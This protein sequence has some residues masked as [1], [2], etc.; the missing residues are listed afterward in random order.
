MKRHKLYLLFAIIVGIM[1]APFFAGC[2]E[3]IKITLKQPVNFGYE[4]N[5]ETGEQ[6]LVVEENPFASSYVFGVCSTKYENDLSKFLRYEFP[7]KYSTTYKGQQVEIPHNFFDV[8][9]IFK[10]AQTYYY[11]V[12]YKGQGKYL[13]SPISEVKSVNITYKLEAPYLSLTDTTL[14]WTSISNASTYSVYSII[15]G[16]RESVATTQETSYDIA[17]YLSDKIAENLGSQIEFFVYCNNTRNYLRSADSNT[18]VYNKHLQLAVPTNVRITNIAGED[19]ICWNP[20]KNCSS[21]TLKVNNIRTEILQVS[22]LEKN[23]SAFKYGLQK[24]YDEYGLGDYT[25]CIKS[26]NSANF[27]ES[28]YSVAATTTITKKL[29]TPQNVR[30]IVDATTVDIMWDIVDNAQE[31]EVEYTDIFD[32]NKIKKLVLNAGSGIESSIIKNHITVTYQQLNIVNG[33]QLQSDSY[34]IR[35][36]AVGYNY[37]LSSDCSTGKTAVLKYQTLDT[38]V[39]Q[40]DAENGLFHWDSIDGAV[41]YRFFIVYNGECEIANVTVTNFDYGIFLT[42]IG[43]YEFYCMAIAENELFNS[44]YSNTIEKE[45]NAVLSKP[46]INDIRIDGDKFVVSFD[47]D[48]NAV[49][50]T[51]YANNVEITDS[52]TI[53]SNKVGIVSAMPYVSNN[54]LLFTIKANPVGYYTGSEMSDAFIFGTEI[55]TPNISISGNMLTWD[56]ISNATSYSIYLDNDMREFSSINTSLDLTNYVAPNTSRQIRLV[57]N[58]LYLGNSDLSNVVMFSNVATQRPG[59]TDKFFNYGQTY[60][61]YITSTQELYDVIGY[62]YFNRISTTDIYLDYDS[63]VSISE[64]VRTAI[65][66]IATGTRNYSA[67]SISNGSRT[68]GPSRIVINQASISSAPTYTANTVQSNSYMSLKGNGSR[69]ASYKFPLEYSIVTQNVYTTDGL[70]AAVQHQVRPR[71]MTENSVE[72]RVYNKAKEVLIEIC[73]D[74]MT[75][76]QKALAIHDWI[77]LNVAYDHQGLNNVS[78]QDRLGYFHYIESALLYKLGVCDSYAKTY[79]LMCSLENIECVVVDGATDKNNQDNTGHSWNKIYLD[80]DADGD[81]EWAIV[82]CTWDDSS[83]GTTEYLKHQYFMIPDSY[84]EERYQA[85]EYPT[86]GIDTDAFYSIYRPYS[87]KLKLDTSSDVSALNSYLYSADRTVEVLVKSSLVSSI[88]GYTISFVYS[89]DENYRVVLVS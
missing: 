69:T 56:S 87:F 76:Y 16:E 14:S 9:N 40:D 28:E 58:N 72:E 47:G 17:E 41:K 22:Q 65:D 88:H 52:L 18:I 37:Y 75:D 6:T 57:A 70:L 63:S 23:G 82:D 83:D 60:D 4:I 54:R 33:L 25:F 86:T 48:I 53:V 66:Y 42:K 79:A 26:N 5:Q 3:E 27:V 81:K 55:R 62:S 45:V 85:K 39:L 49:T 74:S 51:L 24:Y 64:K 19:Y 36:K 84:F 13:N 34:I 78:I 61:Y 12:Q 68:T 32:N 21:Y 59:Y 46:S 20:V 10:N 15:D 1:F 31:Y 50:F 44:A 43:T 38:P 7:A 30:C 2:G 29:D 11:Y 71:F 73:D 67:P 35:V 80:T 77:C 8:T 89:H